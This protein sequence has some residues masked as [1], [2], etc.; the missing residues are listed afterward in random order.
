MKVSNSG[1]P[2]RGSTCYSPKDCGLL[3]S[4]FLGSL[5]CSVYDHDVQPGQT[6]RTMNITAHSLQQYHC[7]IFIG[8]GC[9][10][11]FCSTS[12]YLKVLTGTEPLQTGQQPHSLTMLVSNVCAK[13]TK[14][15]LVP[16]LGAT[17][18]QGPW[19]SGL[20]GYC[21][22]DLSE[23]WEPHMTFHCCPKLL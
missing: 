6:R 3:L 5:M 1:C 11:S 16:G 14:S 8:Q 19:A 15:S 22:P 9:T 12:E 10:F 2:I 21:L 7:G 20:P 4:F 17:L 23:H 18:G 13:Q